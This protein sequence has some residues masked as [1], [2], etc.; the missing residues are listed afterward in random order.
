MKK[1][2]ILGIAVALA[3]AAYAYPTLGGQ[4][5]L[6]T[7]PTAAVAPAGQ[8]QAA[9]DWFYTFAGEDAIIPIRVLYG[10]NDQFEIGAAFFT[11]EGSDSDAFGINAKYMLPFA[12]GDAAWAVGASF[13]DPDEGDSSL[14]VNLSATRQFT[15]T[16]NGTASL[17]WSDNNGMIA[18]EF[19]FDGED[20]ALGLGGEVMLESGLSLIGE[21]VNF[22]PGAILNMAARYPLTD[23]LTAQ[24]GFVFNTSSPF[25]G[26]NYAF[27]GAEE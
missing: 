25:L 16:F 14:A 11:A 2:L 26:F 6:V 15:E 17:I 20:L 19:G 21:Y 18:D 8:F 3:C 13:V 4:T 22:L 9:M 1:L 10:I 7:V 24:L 27:G 12:L 5:G 23:A